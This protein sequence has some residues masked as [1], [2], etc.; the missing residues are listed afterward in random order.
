M[1]GRLLR[2]D[3]TISQTG[4]QRSNMCRLNNI[5]SAESSSE[6]YAARPEPKS[7]T[8][9]SN[10]SA[11]AL[12][13]TFNKKKA[14]S[15]SSNLPHGASNYDVLC[16]RNKSSYNHV[17]NH[18]FRITI[19]IFLQEYIDNTNRAYRSGLFER[20]SELMKTCGSRFWKLVNDEWIIL[21]E[22]MSRHKISHAL[23][24]AAALQASKIPVSRT[25]KQLLLQQQKKKLT[26]L[27]KDRGVE[28]KQET[29]AEAE[30]DM[31][32]ATPSEPVERIVSSN[33]TV[34]LDA[35]KPVKLV[36][37]S[38]CSWQEVCDFRT[39][40][41]FPVQSFT[42]ASFID[43]GEDSEP[44]PLTLKSRQLSIPTTRLNNSVN[45]IVVPNMGNSNLVGVYDK[46]K[47]SDG[48]YR[49][50]LQDWNLVCRSLNSA[51]A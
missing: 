30:G 15:S 14:T 3:S 44:V 24:D 6:G 9:L 2:T 12:A 34:A 33:T 40:E 43:G 36:S 45:K 47:G 1:Q 13:T 48:T 11:L 17:G 5:S 16:G 32:A 19:S 50:K 46:N 26:P 42:A 28:A 29:E 10:S 7:S 21:D 8:S 25:G 4:F 51:T 27:N 20:I 22:S 18:R 49:I 23:R 37:S 31:P 35:S 39:A 38:M 41:P